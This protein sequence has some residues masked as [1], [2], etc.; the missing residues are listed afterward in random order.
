MAGRPT[1]VRNSKL[2]SGHGRCCIT[3]M[4]I[5][6]LLSFA[7]SAQ[8][9][10][11]KDCDI[12]ALQICA[13][14]VLQDEAHIVT[15]PLRIQPNDLL[16]IAPFAAG[17]GY[18]LT[19]D[20]SIMQDLGQNPIREK[21]FNTASNILGIY[22]PAAYSA[23]GFVAGSINHDE[24]LR[25]TS[26]LVT[27]AGVDAL[28]LNT[29]LQYALDRQDPKQGNHKGDFWPHGTKTW[30]DGTSM[31]SEHCIN[32]WS[33]ARVVASEYPGWRTRLIVYS[34]AT[35]VSFSRVLARQHFPS[36]VIVGSTFGYLIGGVVIHKRAAG[37]G[38]LSLSS[39][40]TANG[41][42]IQ[43]SYDFNH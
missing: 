20:A 36:D 27:E 28:I 40:Q 34:M 17:T 38:G 31:P 43:L 3:L 2:A 10:A 13:L 15:S 4:A 37:M 29:G 6:L 25:E 42:G 21:H 22:A 5:T 19:Q 41:K 11:V 8:T 24:H 12:N 1:G 23:V 16:W 26:M 7:A 9:P 33:F 18:T 30:S 39:I 14:H 35:T 32:V